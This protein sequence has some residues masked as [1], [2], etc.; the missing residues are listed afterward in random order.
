MLIV[1][2]VAI[3]SEN[4]GALAS[5]GQWKSVNLTSA[6]PND[7][8]FNIITSVSTFARHWSDKKLLKSR[9]PDLFLGCRWGA[10]RAHRNIHGWRPSLILS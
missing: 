7:F 9:E 2:L 4:N 5:Q 1:L 8:N 10:S 3:W 6:I